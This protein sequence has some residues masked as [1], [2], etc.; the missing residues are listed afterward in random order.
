MSMTLSEAL[1]IRAA[2]TTMKKKLSDEGIDTDD[3]QYI[4]DMPAALCGLIPDDME[5][6]VEKLM[7]AIG[8]EGL[9]ALLD[10]FTS[11]ARSGGLSGFISAILPG[12]K[13]EEGD[14]YA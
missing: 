4:T 7:E 10:S 1:S 14:L 8:E 5:E 13:V 9:L 11:I 3:I 12:D 2:F 6:E